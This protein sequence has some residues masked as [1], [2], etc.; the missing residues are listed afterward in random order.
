MMTQFFMSHWAAWAALCWEEIR[1]FGLM[2]V[3]AWLT[4]ACSNQA[5]HCGCSTLTV[6]RFEHLAELLSLCCL[7][8]CGYV[9]SSFLQFCVRLEPENHIFSCNIKT[10]CFAAFLARVRFSLFSLVCSPV[11]TTER[12]K[13]VWFHKAALADK[14]A[15]FL[16]R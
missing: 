14:Q 2:V 4:W 15:A 12:L 5:C 6:Y 9:L 1:M 11:G 13:R 10:V 16:G 3:V 7:L 8:R